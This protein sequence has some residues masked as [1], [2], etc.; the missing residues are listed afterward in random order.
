[1]ARKQTR[2][3]VSLNGQLRARLQQ[4]AD[5][6]GVA[7]SALTEFWL[8]SMLESG[9]DVDAFDAWHAER[10]ARIDAQKLRGSIAYHK[11]QRDPAPVPSPRQPRPESRPLKA[12]RY[13]R[14]NGVSYAEAARIFGCLPQTKL[15][16]EVA[17]AKLEDEQTEQ[18]EAVAP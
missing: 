6:R 15:A 4:Y 2:R 16:G 7:T 3:T 5:Q 18:P 1:M 10:Q 17:L 8:E 12:A 13:A 14:D 9:I 11:E